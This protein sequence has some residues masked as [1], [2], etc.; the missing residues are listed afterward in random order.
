MESGFLFGPSLTN[1]KKDKNGNDLEYN[2]AGIG[3]SLG[4]YTLFPIAGKFGFRSEYMIS[5]RS[6]SYD[7][8]KFY[9]DLFGQPSGVEGQINNRFF[10]VD[11][12]LMLNFKANDNFHLHTGFSLNYT[13]IGRYKE[14]YTFEDFDING[15]PIIVSADESGK[16]EEF[17]GSLQVGYILGAYYQTEGSFG[18]GLRQQ[19]GMGEDRWSTTQ[20]ML[21]FRF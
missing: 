4:F 17:D 9:D 20:L 5:T 12:P 11:V 15:N 3:G 19:F 1:I 6:F 16:I 7:I 21:G 18:I 2:K 10:G 8:G 14:D 13:A